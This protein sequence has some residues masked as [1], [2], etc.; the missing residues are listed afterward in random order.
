MVTCDLF[1]HICTSIDFHAV[2]TWL[3]FHLSYSAFLSCPQKHTNLNNNNIKFSE[4]ML[5]LHLNPKLLFTSLKLQDF[6]IIV[7]SKKLQKRFKQTLTN[8]CCVHQ[9]AETCHYD[10]NCYKQLV[11]QA[12]NKEP[13]IE[14]G[15]IS[16][17]HRFFIL[18]YLM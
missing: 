3:S 17:R 7:P 14:G 16:K 9:F 4:Q 8:V 13:I 12:C 2:K 1:S 11:N 15:Q 18:T 5:S 10:S 6:S